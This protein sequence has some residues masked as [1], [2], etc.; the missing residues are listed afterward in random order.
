MSTTAE[1]GAPPPAERPPVRVVPI[2]RRTTNE[3]RTKA[4]EVALGQRDRLYDLLAEGQSEQA[5]L[6][7]ALG[8]KL[9][10]MGTTVGAKLDVV[11]ESVGGL[12]TEIAS[13]QVTPKLITLLGI[14]LI[15]GLIALGV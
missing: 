10:A 12:K 7:G 4:E 1:N 3:E 15:A 13:L 8:D 11:N 6:L 5:R 14:G 2:T 9:D